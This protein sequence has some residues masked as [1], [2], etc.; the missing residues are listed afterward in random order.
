MDHN[1]FFDISGLMALILAAL[2][3]GR[4]WTWALNNAGVTILQYGFAFQAILL[5]HYGLLW[6]VTR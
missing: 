1:L 4:Q 6:E 5:F 3:F 2:S